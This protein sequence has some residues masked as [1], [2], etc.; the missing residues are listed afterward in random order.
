MGETSGVW[1]MNR[2]QWQGKEEQVEDVS[3][4]LSSSLSLVDGE[5]E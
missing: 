2:G 1:E 3:K 5:G 4:I